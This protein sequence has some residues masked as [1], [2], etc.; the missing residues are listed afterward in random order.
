MSM[1]TYTNHEFTIRIGKQIV[2]KHTIVHNQTTY[3]ISLQELDIIQSASA[4]E[5]DNISRGGEKI[6]EGEEGIRRESKKGNH[7]EL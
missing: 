2:K 6:E 3:S 4:T 7:E 1:T 5:S